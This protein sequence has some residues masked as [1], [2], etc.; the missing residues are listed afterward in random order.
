MANIALKYAN[1]RPLLAQNAWNA[2]PE[3]QLN[4]DRNMVTR[5]R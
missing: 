4:N 2:D 3:I 1:I 5:A